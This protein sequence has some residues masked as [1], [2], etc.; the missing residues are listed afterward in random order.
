VSIIYGRGEKNQLESTTTASDGLKKDIWERLLA[1]SS[2][3][4]LGKGKKGSKRLPYHGGRT[5][6]Y[7]H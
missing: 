6:A 1:D 3:M 7:T 2:P 4:E 5:W